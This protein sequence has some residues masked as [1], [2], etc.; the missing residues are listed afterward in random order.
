[1]YTEDDDKVSLKKNNSNGDYSNFYTSFSEQEDKGKKNKKTKVAKPKNVELKDE[2]DYTDFYGYDDSEENIT[3]SSFDSNKKKKF[4]KIAIAAFLLIVF[5]ILIIILIR[6]VPKVKGDIEL[7]NENITLNVGESAFISYKIVDT[8]SNVT[9]VF[10]SSNTDVVLV[11]DTG[12]VKAMKKGDA[13]ITIR[14]TIDGV[15]REK[16]CNITVN[17]SGTVEQN[18]NLSLKFQN[19]SNNIWTNSN[20]VI[21]VDASSI[22]GISSLK[23]TTNCDGNC[24]YYDVSNNKI[25]IQNSGI[26]R[27]KVLAKDKKNQEITKEVTVKID[28][29]APKVTL[30]SGRN[31]VS[32]KEVSV[33]ATCSD[34]L[35]G[36]KQAT[37]CKKYTSSASKQVI[38]VED[39]AGNK[40]S[41]E[42]FDVTINKLTATCTLKVSSDGIVSATLR[43]KPVYYGFNSNYSGNNELSKRITINAYQNGESLAKVVYYYVK[44]KSGNTGRCFITVI[45]ECHCQNPKTNDSKC[46]VTCTYKSQ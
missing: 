27:V 17:G 35:S 13:V 14:Y 38:T 4:I 7:T 23:Y 41:T 43:D 37:V 40:K 31:V 3:V 32:N 45:K 12:E 20:V 19:G 30:N 15:T 25:T 24:K 26:T 9:S 16:K 28:K 6:R 11:N 46:S 34:S 8:E 22:F 44:D 39:N 36:C 21:Q 10:S 29:D 5:I 18:V 2:R 42:T 1:M 33:C